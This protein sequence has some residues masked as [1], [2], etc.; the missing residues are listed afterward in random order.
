MSTSESTIASGDVKGVT[1]GDAGVCTR[2][3][4]S[5]AEAGDAG[6]L[7][8]LAEAI[9]GLTTAERETLRELLDE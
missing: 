1:A 6:R 7:R 2:V 8:A 9:R 4:T 3:C 5:E